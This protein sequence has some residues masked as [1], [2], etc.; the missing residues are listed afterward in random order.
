MTARVPEF[1]IF[2]ATYVLTLFALMS[3][4]IPGALAADQE[5]NSVIIAILLRLIEPTQRTATLSLSKIGERII[6]QK[7]G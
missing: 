2:S 3:A 6:Q 5:G 1:R 7:S 4:A